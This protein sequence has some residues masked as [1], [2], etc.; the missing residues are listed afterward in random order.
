MAG[1]VKCQK[2]KADRHSRQTKL[3]VMPTEERPLKEIEMDFVGE[4]LESE[5]FY[6]ILVVTD[7]FSKVQYYILAKTTCTAENIADSYIN[8]IWKLCGLLSHISMDRGPQ[9]SPEIPQR[10]EPKAPHYPTPLYRLLSTN[11]W[12]QRISSPDTQVVSSHLLLR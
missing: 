9:L 6:A 7:W 2:S 8:D 11:R 10:A 4:L 12:T 3:V 1:C 5:A